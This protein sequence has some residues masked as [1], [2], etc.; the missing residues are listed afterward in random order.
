MGVWAYSGVSGFEVFWH[1][2]GTKV[3]PRKL[4]YPKKKIHCSAGKWTGGVNAPHNVEFF[5]EPFLVSPN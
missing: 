1:R 5:N 4:G 3:F 2:V